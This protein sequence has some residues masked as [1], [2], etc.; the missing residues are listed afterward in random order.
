MA[1]LF[2]R[3]SAVQNV[4]GQDRQVSASCGSLREPT[5]NLEEEKLR[6]KVISSA[7]E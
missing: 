5:D 1:S 7:I 3:R 2:T 4:R 6:A